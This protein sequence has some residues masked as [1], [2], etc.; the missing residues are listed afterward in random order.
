MKKEQVYIYCLAIILA[1]LKML[2]GDFLL[3]QF[4]DARCMSASAY[5]HGP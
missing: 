1:P 3:T 2:G 5:M 4:L